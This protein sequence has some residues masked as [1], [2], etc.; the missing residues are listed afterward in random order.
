[1][2][3]GLVAIAGA[4]VGLIGLLAWAMVRVSRRATEMHGREMGLLDHLRELRY[5]VLASL[6]AVAAASV[7]L[8]SFDVRPTGLF[9]Y[10]VWVPVPTVMES[11]AS[12]GLDWIL[13][14]VLPPNVDVV[15]IQPTEA[16]MAQFQ[17]SLVGA[18]AIAAPFVAYQVAAFLA[19]ALHPDERRTVGWLLPVALL[20]FLAGMAF[21]LWLMVPLTLR[22]LYQYA[23]P[24]GA[25]PLAQPQ[26]IVTFVLFTTFLFGVAFETPLVMAGLSRSGVLSPAAMAKHWRGVIVGVLVTA[27]V[28]TDPNPV[29]QMLVGVPLVLLYFAGL[30][31]AKLAWREPTGVGTIRKGSQ[32]PGG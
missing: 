2:D 20:L 9:G 30:G 19:P 24:I 25:N 4:A 5:R 3:L 17:A 6:G 13:N 16:I 15:V 28:V 26:E 18:L 11:L 14:H 7:A 23:E 29:T 10:R 32:G 27:A 8:F 12:R 1:V 22:T 31:C 21:A